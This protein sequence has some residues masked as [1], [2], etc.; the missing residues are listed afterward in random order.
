MK[1]SNEKSQLMSVPPYVFGCIAT[2]LGGYFAD[3]TRQRGIFMMF[4]CLVAILGFVL[5]ISTDKP[6]VQYLGTFFAV[7]G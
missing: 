7:A 1:Y 4:F 2:I 6:G 3:R 5:L